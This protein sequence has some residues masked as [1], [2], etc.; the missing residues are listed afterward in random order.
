MQL[1]TCTYIY[2]SQIDGLMY[3]AYV[4]VINTVE[5]CSTHSAHFLSLQ[6]WQR[7]VLS[8]IDIRQK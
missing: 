5:E 6:I 4:K 1:K 2:S 8:Y 3:P 7:T